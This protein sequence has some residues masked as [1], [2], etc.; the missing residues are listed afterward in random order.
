M[1]GVLF[2]S[3]GLADTND[4]GDG[5]DTNVV[6]IAVPVAVGGVLLL[7]AAVVTVAIALAIWKRHQLKVMLQAVGGVLSTDCESVP[8]PGNTSTEKKECC[9]S[10]KSYVLMP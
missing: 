1:K 4:R 3:R 2:E 9:K 5:E 10:T 6:V 7:S 8:A